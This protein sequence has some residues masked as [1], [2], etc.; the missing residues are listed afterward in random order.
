[1]KS[2]RSQQQSVD[3]QQQGPASSLVVYHVVTLSI[4]FLGGVDFIRTGGMTLLY[5]AVAMTS[6]QVGKPTTKNLLLFLKETFFSGK[7]K[8]P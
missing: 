8:K 6:T 4:L 7:F 3:P 2:I 5:I 1:M